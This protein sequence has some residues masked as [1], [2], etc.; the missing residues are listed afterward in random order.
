VPRSLR[1]AR[2]SDRVLERDS[3]YIFRGIAIQP[4]SPYKCEQMSGRCQAGVR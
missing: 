4:L 2:G 1:I 3:P